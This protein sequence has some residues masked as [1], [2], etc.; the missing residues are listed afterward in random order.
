[1]GFTKHSRQVDDSMNPAYQ[2]S[3]PE[4]VGLN[5]D[6]ET[7]L[8]APIAMVGSLGKLVLLSDPC[9]ID[10]R[11]STDDHARHYISYE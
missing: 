10:P 1:M 11:R 6:D 9:L 7:F 5:V 4:D 3:R 2:V 8:F